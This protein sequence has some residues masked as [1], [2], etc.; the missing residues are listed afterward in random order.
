MGSMPSSYR[1]LGAGILFIAL[2]LVACSRPPA[3]TPGPESDDVNLRPQLT[4]DAIP[5]LY[6]TYTRPSATET[7]T[8]VPQDTPTPRS[9]VD[10]EQPVVEFRYRIPALQL[11]RRL[12]ANV[13]GQITVVDEALGLASIRQNQGGILLELQDALPDVELEPLPDG[14]ES[15]VAFSYSLPIDDV[16]DE[17]WL[18]DPVML[19]SVENFTSVAVGP[20]FPP[21]TILGLRR[22]A[23]AY[24]VAHSLALTSDGQLWRWLATEAQVAAPTPV[25]EAAPQ[26]PLL[27]AD[28]PLQ[29]LVERYVVEC[30]GAPAETLFLSPTGAE[31]GSTIEIGCP[32]FSLPRPMLPLYLE[33]DRLLQEVLP[34]GEPVRPPLEIPLATVLDYQRADDAR[35]TV[36]LDGTAQATKPAGE[37]ITTTLTSSQVLSVTTAL[38]ESDVLQ[39]GLEAYVAG[40]TPNILLVRG[41]RGMSEL[42]WAEEDGPPEGALPQITFLDS[43]M[44]ELLAESETAGERIG[45]Q[46]SPT[47]SPAATATP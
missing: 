24:D 11:D 10:F 2:L 45:P 33:M 16:A 17:G 20:H 5:T 44:D 26:L 29:S 47:P 38:V 30:P 32:A 41:L 6:P 27:L 18:R 23:T 1:K 22:S 15:C 43:L 14:C 9:T 8:A 37:T 28:L 42:A 31:E 39:P 35:L 12:E 19:A 4:P 25:E 7:A 40:I 46:P 34:D 3:E 13:N 21:D 36:L